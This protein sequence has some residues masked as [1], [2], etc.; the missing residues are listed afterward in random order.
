MMKK[1]KLTNDK[2]AL[3]DDEDYEWLNQF[4]WFSEK[5]R[6][7]YYVASCINSVRT[8][9]HRFILELIDRKIIIDH[10]DGN[11][12][13]N[14]RNNLRKCTHAEN[15]T[16][17]KSA[18]NSSSKYLGVSMRCTKTKYVSKKTGIETTHFS[19]GWVATTTIDNKCKYL[20]TFKTE[21]E[22]A[23]IYNIAARKYHG[24]FANPNKFN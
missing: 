18:K 5:G 12:L 15:M 24:E 13:N 19:F 23:I 3:V 17:R 8:R 4:K 9:M 1:I 6:N 22:A 2:Y 21:L 10:K 20:G 7:T 11:G 14:Q 16:N